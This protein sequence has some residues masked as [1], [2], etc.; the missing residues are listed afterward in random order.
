MGVDVNFGMLLFSSRF[1]VC[2]AIAL[3]AMKSAEQT[4]Q[5]YRQ[6]CDPPSPSVA[7]LCC[8]QPQAH[9]FNMPFQLASAAL[10]PETDTADAAQ[11]YE[12]EM[13]SGDVVV[14]ATDGLFDNMWDDQLADIVSGALE[15][16]RQR[17]LLLESDMTLRTYSE[18]L[19]TGYGRVSVS[20]DSPHVRPSI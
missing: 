13:E 5:F 10:L 8:A 20:F 6:K 18:E 4:P 9:Q 19:A 12:L 7:V 3:S 16:E 17:P 11:L 2:V 14:M 15:V 1:R